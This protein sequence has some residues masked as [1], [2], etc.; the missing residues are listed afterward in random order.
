[1]GHGSPLERCADC[2]IWLHG[3]GIPAKRVVQY[4]KQSSPRAQGGNAAYRV[5]PLILPRFI[6]A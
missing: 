5:R 1:M 4:V 2:Q 6:G 3:A